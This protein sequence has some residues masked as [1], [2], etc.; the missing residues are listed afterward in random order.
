V[1]A[2]RAGR[3][4]PVHAGG[5]PERA[6]AGLVAQVAAVVAV[7]AQ[8]DVSGVDGHA[9]AEQGHHHLEHAGQGVI[10]HALTRDHSASV[11]GVI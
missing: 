9:G 2:I 4:S 6:G 10:G 5:V 1:P 8:Q 11:S 7:A 3:D